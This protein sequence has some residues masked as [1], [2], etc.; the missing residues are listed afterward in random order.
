MSWL[1]VHSHYNSNTIYMS[2]TNTGFL[3][4]VCKWY[5]NS[6]YTS[7]QVIGSIGDTMWHDLYML[8]NLFS[9]L[10]MLSIFWVTYEFISF[11]YIMEF[12]K[13]YISSTLKKRLRTLLVPDNPSVWEWYYLSSWQLTLRH[14]YRF[15]SWKLETILD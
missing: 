14:F 3:F 10:I 7:G 4:W 11:C 1:I 6:D 9:W 2:K 13:T 8:Y 5:P 12:H 15:E